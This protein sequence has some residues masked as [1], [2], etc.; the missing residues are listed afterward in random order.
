[1]EIVPEGPATMVDGAAGAA[2]AT[3]PTDAPEIAIVGATATGATN[4]TSGAQAMAEASA[5]ACTRTGPDTEPSTTV[6][7]ETAPENSGI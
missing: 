4:L 1:M 3:A 7:P 6:A 2:T 5:P